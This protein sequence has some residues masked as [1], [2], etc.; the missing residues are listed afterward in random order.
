MKARLESARSALSAALA[1]AAAGILHLPSTATAAPVFDVATSV[2]AATTAAV[3]APYY[4]VMLKE[5]ALG[6]Y[7]GDKP[8]LAA[9][10]RIAARGAVSRVA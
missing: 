7:A 6:S 4:F 9:P 3:D 1:I 10:A 5:P 8:G 2:T